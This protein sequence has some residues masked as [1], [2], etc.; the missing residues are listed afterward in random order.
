MLQ[1]IFNFE[2]LSKVISGKNSIKKVNFFLKD[3][4]FKKIGLIIDKNL[5]KSSVYVKTFSK[6]IKNKKIIFF[7]GNNE[8]TYTNLDTEVRKIKKSQNIF[9]CLV[10]IGGG[11]TIDFAK[12]IAT[13]LKNPGKSINYRGFPKNLKLSIP[14]IAVP[15]TA[16]TGSELAYNAVFTDTKSQKK[17]GINTKNNYPILSILDP[18]VLINSP[19][20]VIL[21]SS[22][23]ALI[24]SFDTMF[25]KKSTKI[26]KIFSENS[27]K[28]VF[29]N[30]SKILK[31]K[32]NIE[33]WSDMQWGSYLS[34]AALL[35]SS[36]GPAGNI[37]YYLS[38]K[39]NIPQGLGYAVAGINFIKRNHEK[40]YYEYS[41]FFDLIEKKLVKNNLSKKEKSFYVINS[42]FK[43]LKNNILFFNKK[44]ANEKQKKN[45]SIL[46]Y[47]EIKNATKNNPINLDQKDLSIIIDRILNTFK[48]K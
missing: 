33:A 16:G 41:K 28:L 38:V 1:K 27:F 37:S 46:M 6:K 8:P 40:G 45:I 22:L 18:L 48:K 35:N 7:D 9:D 25:N 31:N 17:L 23:G 19:R 39:N 24:R 10:A 47:Q 43:I 20:S 30:F 2:L 14:I 4:N 21:N 12:G 42:V 32:K 5:Y 36:S 13:M 26:S 15:S 44:I 34:V 11:S 29:N 3:K